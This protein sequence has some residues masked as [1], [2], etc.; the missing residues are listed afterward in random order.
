MA[1]LQPFTYTLL[2]QGEIRLLCASV[3]GD[4]ITWTLKPERVSYEALSDIPSFDALSYAWGDLDHTFPF[5]CNAQELRI[6]KNLHE[7]LPYLARRQAGRPIWIDAVC[8][9]QS[10]MAEKYA[11]VRLMHRVY[12]YAARVYI[13]LGCATDYTQDAISLLRRF[14]IMARMVAAWHSSNSQARDICGMTPASIGLPEASSP[15]WPAI[16]A[17]LENVWFRRVWVV[18]EAALARQ[19]FFLCGPFDIV[20]T[21]MSDAMASTYRIRQTRYANQA[22]PGVDDSYLNSRVF[23]VRKCFHDR[24]RL[25][26]STAKS[27]AFVVAVMLD[28][29]CYSP[30][31]RVWGIMAFLEGYEANEPILND[32][33]SVVELYTVFCRYLFTADRCSQACWLLIHRASLAGKRRGLPSWCPD[34][35]HQHQYRPP[36]SLAID[37]IYEGKAACAASASPGAIRCGRSIHEIVLKGLIFDNVSQVYTT[38]PAMDILAQP[39]HYTLDVQS[40]SMRDL[41]DWEQSIAEN[42]MGVPA[43]DIMGIVGECSGGGERD[44]K[45]V[46]L[47]TYWRTLIGLGNRTH[48]MGYKVTLQTY[49]QFRTTLERITALFEKS[50]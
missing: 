21:T 22:R 18:Q 46:T 45:T 39:G 6:H 42:I 7:A 5:I 47:D 48:I 16:K 14:P 40:Q 31:D 26:W 49:I 12:R 1:K 38:T 19:P 29:Q 41:R 11:Q 24:R 36:N 44:L 34:L 13:W 3:E 35:H 10:D 25:D 27:M 43:T 4:E 8:I 15:I 30:A 28:H 17:I 32:T 9:N 23:Q 33:M 37:I 20:W 50:G 2:S